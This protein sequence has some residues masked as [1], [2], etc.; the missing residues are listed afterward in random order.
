[1]EGDSLYG[2]AKVKKYGA[3]CNHL[4]NT[5][6]DVLVRHDVSSS[7]TLQGL[8]LRYGCTVSNLL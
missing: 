6:S 5:T 1:M 2:K 8:S 4:R 7:D 3:T